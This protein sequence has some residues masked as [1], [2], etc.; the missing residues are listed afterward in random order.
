M[1]WQYR[2]MSRQTKLILCMCHGVK[3]SRESQFMRHITVINMPEKRAWSG[4]YH[5][6][7]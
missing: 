2:K 4:K 7:A 1:F 3:M 5:Y 6:A